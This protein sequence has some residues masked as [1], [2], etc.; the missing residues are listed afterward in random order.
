V[1]AFVERLDLMRKEHAEGAA[2]H[3]RVVA[4]LRS[5]AAPRPVFVAPRISASQSPRASLL[6][7]YIGLFA[8]SVHPDA[9]ASDPS[10]VRRVTDA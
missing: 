7:L 6:A 10:P 2:V 1:K 5:W 3:L 4:A 9:H 8:E